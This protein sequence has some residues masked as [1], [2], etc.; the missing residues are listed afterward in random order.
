MSSGSAMGGGGALLS[1]SAAD[2]LTYFGAALFLAA[3]AALASGVPA[4]RAARVDPMTSLR[5]Q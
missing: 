3:V 5:C 4:I 2:P 1:V